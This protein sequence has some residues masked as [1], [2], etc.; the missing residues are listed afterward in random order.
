MISEIWADMHTA[1]WWVSTLIVGAINCAIWLLYARYV[2]G[3][4]RPS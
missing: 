3:W 1:S 2:L 4:R